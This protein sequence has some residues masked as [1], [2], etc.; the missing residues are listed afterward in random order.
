M[1]M[2]K[3]SARAMALANAPEADDAET[4]APDAGGEAHRPLLRP[5]AG[6]YIGVAFG[7]GP[8]GGQQ[9]GEGHVG[10]ILGE[11]VGRVGHGDAAGAGGRQ[12]DGVTPTP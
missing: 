7:D 5:G 12:V 6:A 11:H 9:Q 8:R 2:P 4:L 3:P 1:D 10:D